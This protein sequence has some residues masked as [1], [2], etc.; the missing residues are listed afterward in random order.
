MDKHIVVTKEHLPQ[1]CEICHQADYFD[2]V[3]NSCSRCALTAT[4]KKDVL[5]KTDQITGTKSQNNTARTTSDFAGI[6]P[7]IAGIIL[8]QSI[9]INKYGLLSV[10]FAISA[11]LFIWGII[12][13]IDWFCLQF[14]IIP[15]FQNYKEAISN[16]ALF[17]IGG[18]CV[19]HQ[20]I[21]GEI[22]ILLSIIATLLLII[23]CLV[24]FK[25]DKKHI[26]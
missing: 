12:D 24:N 16:I 11:I 5:A 9:H 2:P 1:R 25:K 10:A 19:R 23:L 17:L 8:S 6:K 26:I 13:L 7:I 20:L 15:P 4:E 22:N 18:V 14:S 3:T 21:N